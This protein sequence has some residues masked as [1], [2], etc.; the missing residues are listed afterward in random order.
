MTLAISQRIFF[1]HLYIPSS[2]NVSVASHFM[3]K[4]S[5]YAPD[6]ILILLGTGAYEH[7]LTMCVMYVVHSTHTHT[8][9]HTRTVA[10]CHTHTHTHTHACTR[11]HTHTCMY[12]S[13][14]VQVPTTHVFENI[15]TT[16][17]IPAVRY[18]V[19]ASGYRLFT[20]FKTPLPHNAHTHTQ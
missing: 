20:V 14:M 8:H 18:H 12:S 4:L 1:L 17:L 19:V 10:T 7:E 2:L 3:A 5:V 15:H 9:T 11:T 6:C 13:Y 16:Q